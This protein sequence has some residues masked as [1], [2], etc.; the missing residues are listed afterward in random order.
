MDHKS[1]PKFISVS[2]QGIAIKKRSRI[3]FLDLLNLDTHQTTALYIFLKVT[4]IPFEAKPIKLIKLEQLTPEYEAINPFKKVPAIEHN[5]FKL[6]ESI[7][8]VR[9]LSREYNI[10][11][12]WYPSSSKEQA[13]VDEYL[14]WQ[15]L[16]TRLQCASY[17]AVKYLNPLRTGRPSKPEQAEKY[18]ASMLDCLSLIE[19][20]W[21]KDKPFLTSDKISVSDIFGVCEVEQLRLAGYDPRESGPVLAEWIE[22]VR[23]ET[24]PYYDEAHKFLNIFAEQQ[25]QASISYSL[26]KTIKYGDTISLVYQE[27]IIRIIQNTI[28]YIDICNNEHIKIS[29][30]LISSVTLETCKISF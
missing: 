23:K 24:N 27:Q 7:A 15:H 16:N 26:N 30:F 13:R 9:Y 14:E 18:K 28:L 29:E 21:L 25:K 4:G 22:R 20:T 12:H 19:N 8:I 5:G 1:T 17:F 6:T 3:N 2:T 11:Q 10:S